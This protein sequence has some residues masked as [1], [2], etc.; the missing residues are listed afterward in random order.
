M[1]DLNITDLFSCVILDRTT[2]DMGNA[3]YEESW[4]VKT[5]NTKCNKKADIQSC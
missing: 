3:K 4:F 5:M 2:Q 1:G